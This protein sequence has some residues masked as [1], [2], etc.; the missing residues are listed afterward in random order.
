MLDT[1][2]WFGHASFRINE[3]PL[4]YIDPWRIPRDATPADVIL[5]T[6]DHYDHYSPPDI[7]K[8]RTPN[9]TI[10]AS[11]R[12]AALMPDSITLRPWQTINVGRAC[13]TAVPA[14]NSHHPATF[15]GVGFVVA[16]NHF[17]I[18]F[19]GDTDLIPEMARIRADVAVLPIGGRQT[20]NVAMA[21]EAAQMVK[22]RYA[23]PSHWGYFYE[24]G[25]SIDARRFVE[26]IS[27]FAEG[28]LLQR[29]D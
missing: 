22:A 5:I 18:Y 17:D 19:A 26:Q 20:M 7:D 25:T 6:H 4:I 16:L 12:A 21:V 11:P 28:R 2:E 13:I 8:I 14:Y 23:V 29:L 3:S 9:T 27:P 1:L 24:G 15:E 10:I